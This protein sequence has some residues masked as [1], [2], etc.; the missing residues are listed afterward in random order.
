[1]DFTPFCKCGN[2]P[3]TPAS[4]SAAWIYPPPISPA[5]TTGSETP[6]FNKP[7]FPRT[8]YS[9]NASAHHAVEKSENTKSLATKN[10]VLRI[11]VV[12]AMPEKR[13]EPH[14]PDC[15]MRA[16]HA[17]LSVDFVGFTAVR[18]M[19]SMIIPATSFFDDC[20]IPSSPG[21]EFTSIT[22]GP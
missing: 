13:V 12:H 16:H 15:A 3:S 5:A 10:G 21:E 17:H 11:A 18:S 22:T 8:S 14:L 4:S 2:L 7:P 20:S 1:M 6:C 9:P 19:N